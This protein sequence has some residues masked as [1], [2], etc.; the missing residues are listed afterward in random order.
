MWLFTKNITTNQLAKKLYHKIIGSFE[1]IGKK[2]NISLNL[3]LFQ[4]IKIYNI[5]QPNF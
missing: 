5:F 1:V 4:A 3:Q 2:D